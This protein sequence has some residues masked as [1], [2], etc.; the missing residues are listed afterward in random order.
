MYDS[1]PYKS[2]INLGQIGDVFV[3]IIDYLKALELL[4]HIVDATSGKAV[5][6]E[7]FENSDILNGSD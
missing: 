4:L 7:M 5:K 2:T 3:E 6:G 1:I